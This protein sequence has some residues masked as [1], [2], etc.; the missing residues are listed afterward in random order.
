MDNPTLLISYSH[1][2]F[3]ELIQCVRQLSE[4]STL[5]YV[6]AIAPILLS[7]VA[8][9]ISILVAQ[10][11]N[12]IAFFEKRFEVFSE[13]QRC[14]A[15]ERLLA[16][17]HTP[18]LAYDAFCVAY[19]SNRQVAPL[20]RGWATQKYIPIEKKLMQ[21]YVLFKGIDEHMISELC[22]SLLA[23]LLQI[24]RQQDMET[25]KVQFQKCTTELLRQF[26]KI[27]NQM[28]LT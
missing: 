22:R 15:F 3:L 12:K 5:D 21:S 4:K 2:D 24:E 16:E 1:N 8:V 9:I 28:K 10:R 7:V 19:G 26:C 6:I 14:L 20:N 11:Q 23:V 17:A 13:I 18:Q 27:Y 25:Q